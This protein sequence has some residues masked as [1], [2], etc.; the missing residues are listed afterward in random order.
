MASSAFGI[1]NPVRASS[2][3]P[4]HQ[5][6]FANDGNATTFWQANANDTNCW[7]Q[8]DVERAVTMEK[9]KLTFPGEGNYRYKIE[10]S[11]DG[12]HWTLADDQTQ[13]TSAEKIRSEVMAKNSGA[14]LLRVVFLGKPAALAEIE[15]FGRLT[16][17]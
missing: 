11:N 16:A 13:T 17:Q 12:A 3:S 14:H 6:S 8:V 1:Y 10:T 4:E 9:V 2:E 5:A 7:W 15:I